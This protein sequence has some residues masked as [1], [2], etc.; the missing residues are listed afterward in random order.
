[1][2]IDCPRRDKW[3]RGCR[4]EARYDLSPADLSGFKSLKGR[5]SAG[6]ALVNAMRKR[7]YTRDICVRCGKAMERETP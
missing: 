3:F 5:G 2:S 7:T 6:V 4:F 1:M